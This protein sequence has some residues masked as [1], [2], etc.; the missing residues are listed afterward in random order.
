MK[1]EA[2]IAPQLHHLHEQLKQIHLD[3]FEKWLTGRTIASQVQDKLTAMHA[4]SIS[5]R[6]VRSYAN[7]WGNNIKVEIPETGVS[8]DE[9]RRFLR[10]W[11]GNDTHITGELWHTDNGL[12][13]S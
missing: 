1:Q 12:A 13:I 6:P 4:G 9:I 10:H 8:V 11:L 5:F 3:I 7:N 2:L